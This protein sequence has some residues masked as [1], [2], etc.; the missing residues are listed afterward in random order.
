VEFAPEAVERLDGQQ[1]FRHVSRYPRRV[2]L[3]AGPQYGMKVNV[4]DLP[5]PEALSLLESLLQGLDG[6]FK[7]SKPTQETNSYV[8]HK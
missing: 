4:K 3:M 2:R 1:L 7:D 5:L 8:V 6:V